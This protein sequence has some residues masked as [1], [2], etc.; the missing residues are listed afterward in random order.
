MV[1]N[2]NRTNAAY[3]IIRGGGEYP[4][5]NGKVIFKQLPKGVLV[6][7][8]INGLPDIKDG[9]GIFAMHIHSG[10]SCTG[11]DIDEFADSMT[12]YNPQNTRHPYHAG[13]LPPLFGNHGFAYMEVFTDRFTLNEIIGKTVIIHNGV[14]NF[15]SQPAGNSGIKIACGKIVRA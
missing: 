6:T 10:G 14:D 13:D 7:V 5:I 3:A 15:T 4:G 12:H 9:M 11:N 2:R 1:S 8:R